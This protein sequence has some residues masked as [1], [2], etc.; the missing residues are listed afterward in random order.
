MRIDIAICTWN[1]AAALQQTLHSMVA[2]NFPDSIDLRFLIVDN[3]SKDETQNVVNSFTNQLNLYLYLEPKRG[4]THARNRAIEHAKSDWLIWTDDD[5]QVTPDWLAAYVDAMRDPKGHTFFGGPIVPTFQPQP[6]AWIKD[7]W[8]KLKGCY[9][10]RQLGENTFEFTAETLPYGAN[11]A[12]QTSLQKRHLFDIQYGRKADGVVGEDELAMLRELMSNGHSG[13]WVP[14]AS[15]FHVIGPDRQ[16]M[17]Y[18][19]NYFVGQGRILAA[20][21]K[22]WTHDRLQLARESRWEGWCAKLKRPFASAD[23]WVSHL[24]RSGLA[25]GQRQELARRTETDS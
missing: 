11:F 22:P 8:S 14:D 9:A 24:I 10:E 4:H 3:G 1:R 6:P 18:V 19:H 7:N 15:L 23:T 12:V 13:R 17:R 2:M 16:T 21:G 5:V 20:K 25:E